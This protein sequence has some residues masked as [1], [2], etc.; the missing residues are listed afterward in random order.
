MGR[1]MNT[2][3]YPVFLHLES[4]TVLIVGFGKVGQRKLLMLAPGRPR[5]V[6]IVD[7]AQPAEEGKKLLDLVASQ[8]FRL[9]YS[10]R[11]FN[12]KDLDE[13]MI[14]FACSDDRELNTKVAR[15]CAERRILC[16]CTNNPPMGNFHVPAM[17]RTKNLCAA[18]S[19]EQGSPAL[20]RRWS[21]EMREY[22]AEREPMAELMARLRP[23]VI[24]QG[25]PAHQNALL[26][27]RIADG[28]LEK[29]LAEKKIEEAK[30]YLDRTLPETLKG[31]ID[32]LLK[33]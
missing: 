19:T 2:P 15:L 11:V 32:E 24:G 8:K 10:R 27:R 25:R 18:L 20:A 30:K 4:M 14:V 12:E 22:L 33:K 21:R 5:H 17:A 1:N 7:P 6:H 23:L 29:L 26:F 3:S 16:N 28:P 9:T 31:H 13:P